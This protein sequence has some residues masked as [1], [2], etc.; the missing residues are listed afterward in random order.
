LR[1]GYAIGHPDVVLELN[2]VA[3]PFRVN[4]LAQ[5]A[6]LASLGADDEMERRVGEVIV[7]RERLGDALRGLGL[8]VPPSQA[9]FVWLGVAERA[10]E[11]GDLAERRGVVFRVFRDVGVR[12]TVGTPEQ[13]D[14]VVKVLQEAVAEGLV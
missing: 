8:E 5:V 11:I 1:V 13:N 7:E 4:T 3:M 2:K 9:N 14:R 6:A 12:I 10:A